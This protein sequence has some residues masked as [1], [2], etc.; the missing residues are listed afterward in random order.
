MSKYAQTRESDFFYW[1]IGLWQKM[2]Y[3]LELLYVIKKVPSPG[4]R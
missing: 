3:Y 2:F 1:E 4:I